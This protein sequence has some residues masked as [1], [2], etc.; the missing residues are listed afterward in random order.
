[1]EHAANTVL[2]VGFQAPDTLGRRLVEGREVVRILGREC[3]V[4]AEVVMMNGLSSHADQPGLLAALAP[5]VGRA[6]VRLVHGEP[7]RSEKLAEA[8]RGA[9]FA[10]VAVPE[11]GETVGV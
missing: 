5:H 1:V 10:D 8:L 11:R 4:R 6:K 3:R 2:I 7:E 9:G